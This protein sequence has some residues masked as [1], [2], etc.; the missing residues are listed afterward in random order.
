MG[1][2]IPR[3][4]YESDDRVDATFGERFRAWWE[5][6]ELAS[7]D[8]DS[9]AEPV[10]DVPDVDE[11]VRP[12]RPPGTLP[13]SAPQEVWSKARRDVVQMIW[14]EGFTRPGGEDYVLSLVN[15]FSLSPADS[16]LEFGCGM[17]G[18]TVAIVDRFG[19]YMNCFERDATLRKEASARAVTHGIDEKVTIAAL[20]EKPANLRDNFFLGALVREVLC[21]LEETEDFL[22]RVIRSVKTEGQ[23][24]VAELMF[25]PDADSPELQ[26][27]LDAERQPCFPTKVNTVRETFGR[28]AMVVRTAAD[29]SDEYRAM[30]IAGWVDLLSRIDSTLN[31]TLADALVREAELW[32]RRIAAI[33]AG[34]LRYYRFVGVKTG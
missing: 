23:L 24:V 30:A 25:D 20:E 5:G 21:T 12:L 18:G 34:V 1:L 19:A 15:A 11:D 27:W 10:V 33:D 7:H 13:A 14:G 17:G 3:I 26:A 8:A 4:F 2:A 22:T 16:A 9:P 32:A 6:Y 31:P 28:N 29:E